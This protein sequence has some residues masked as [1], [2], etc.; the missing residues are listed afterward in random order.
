LTR[1]VDDLMDVSRV[2]MGR[3][4]LQRSDVPVNRVLRDA[5]DTVRREMRDRRHSFK[6][7]LPDRNLMVNADAVRL[8]QVIVNLLTNAAKYTA[9]GGTIQLAAERD[10]DDAL[11]RVRDSG[12]GIEPELLPH[13][14]ALFSQGSTTLDRAKGGL[15]IGLALVKYLVEMHG[16]SVTARSDGPGTGSEFIVRLPL[17][18]GE[19]AAECEQP[20]LPGMGADAAEDSLRV[21]VVDDNRDSADL[22]A[23]LLHHNGYKVKTAYD[24]TDA[25]EIA[26]R[27][28]PDAILLD[29]GLPEIDGYEVA[30]RVRQQKA[31]NSVVLIAMTGYGQPEDRQR[32]EAVGFDYHL[33]KPAEFSELQAILKSVSEARGH[34]A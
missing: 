26:L 4:Q 11:L 30:Y 22:Q 1:L 33:V 6:L 34:G 15:G 21:L 18:S 8:E 24:G 13:V 19:P 5:A 3:V 10:G 32:S 25:L 23:T 27:F 20:L 9:D 17:A 14:F 12:I 31:L 28:H 7:H 16:G 2:T 29:I